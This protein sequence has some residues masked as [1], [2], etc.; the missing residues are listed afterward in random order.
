MPD[1]VILEIFKCFIPARAIIIIDPIDGPIGI[2]EPLDTQDGSLNIAVT[3]KRFANLAFEL[4]YGRC[5][6]QIG[7]DS[8]ARY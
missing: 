1:E 7:H 8:N 4:F 6:L 3:C 5:K 2:K